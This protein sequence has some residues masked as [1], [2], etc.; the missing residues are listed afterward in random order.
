[1]LLVYDKKMKSKKQLEIRNLLL[2]VL[3]T[4]TLYMLTSKNKL[5]KGKM[6]Y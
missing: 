3:Y 5:L 6:Y 2:M 4:S 1:M